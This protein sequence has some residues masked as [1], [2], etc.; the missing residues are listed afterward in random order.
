M[1][2]GVSHHVC[3]GRDVDMLFILACYC[4]RPF[5]CRTGMA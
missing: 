1:I 5:V 3:V 4:A 2:G